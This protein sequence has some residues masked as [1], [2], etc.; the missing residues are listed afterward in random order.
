MGPD[1]ITKQIKTYGTKEITLSNGSRLCYLIICDN[2]GKL[3]YKAQCEIIRG[4]RRNKRFFC[5]QECNY[6]Y[7][8]TKQEVA[9]ANCD[10]T[11]YKIPS[12]IAKTN[13]NF[14]S[15]SCAATYNN[16]HKRFGTRRS[17]LENL[18][19]GMLLAEYPKITFACNQKDIIGSELDFYFPNLK[20]AVQINGPLHYLP[21]YGQKKLDQ[22]QRMDEEKRTVCNNKGIILVEVDCSEDKYLNKKKIEERLSQ[23][24]AILAEASELASHTL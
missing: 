11:F 22:I 16:K 19:E 5:S 17:K 6:A 7:N 14:C 18:I 21:I 1:Q 2:C 8:Y 15:K 23:I 20:L 12:Q 4:L 9:C 10:T 24:K 3:H 13:N